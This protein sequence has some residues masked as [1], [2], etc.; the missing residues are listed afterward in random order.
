MEPPR[1]GKAGGERRVEHGE[2]LG[3]KP[4]RMIE[5]QILLVAL[6]RHAHPLREDALEM[7]GAEAD[8]RRQI[9]ERKRRASGVDFGERAGDHG[10][11]V[12]GPLGGEAVGHGG[13]SGWWG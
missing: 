2:P 1:P 11:M 3:Q 12:G 13:S 9:L 6:G 7:G 10:I 8:P 4:P 5:R